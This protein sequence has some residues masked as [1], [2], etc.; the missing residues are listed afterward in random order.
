MAKKPTK[1]R[2]T[3]LA[4]SA[5]PPQAI[6]GTSIVPEVAYRNDHRPLGPG[7]WKGEP[8]KFAWT[9]QATGYPCV[10]VRERGGNY[11]A[12]VGLPQSHPLSGYR[13]RALPGEISEGL[14]RPV[15]RAEPCERRAPEPIS[16]CHVSERNAHLAQEQT[17]WHADGDDAWW[18]GMAF[19][20]PRDLVPMQGERKLA[21]ERGE[22]YRDAQFAFQQAT[23]LARRLYDWDKL[24]HC[25]P[26]QLGTLPSGDGQ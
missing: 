18:L 6:P 23:L 2:T 9:D 19:D 12:H 8:D 20:G 5:L 16:I 22:T 21:A 13:A 11:G 7:P 24:G 15:S 1:T 17:P 26:S 14:H 4:V 25:Q 3:A 10:V